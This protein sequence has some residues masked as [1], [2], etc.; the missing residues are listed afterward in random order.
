MTYSTINNYYRKHL[1]TAYKTIIKSAKLEDFKPL[2]MPDPPRLL[3]SVLPDS[4][5]VNNLGTFFNIFVKIEDLELII[6]NIN[7]YMEAYTSRY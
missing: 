1:Y 5:D 7:K 6:A 4:A 3:Y 2:E